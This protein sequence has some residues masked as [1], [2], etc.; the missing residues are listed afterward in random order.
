MRSF[1]SL[2][3]TFL[4]FIAGKLNTKYNSFYWKMNNH[5][6]AKM[7]GIDLKPNGK[8]TPVYLPLFSITRRP[9]EIMFDFYFWTT[10]SLN[11]VFYRRAPYFGWAVS[12]KFVLDYGE[13]EDD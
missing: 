12:N 3:R 8:Y 4:V 11:F 2:A 10:S 7:V 5:Y 6:L 9:G 1:E 13:E